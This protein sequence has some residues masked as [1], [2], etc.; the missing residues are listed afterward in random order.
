MSENNQP[1]IIKKYLM[2]KKVIPLLVI[3]SIFSLVTMVSATTPNPGHPWTEVGDGIW[4]ATGMTGFR[5]YTFPDATATVLT[6]NAL[7]TVAQ[8]GTG[9]NSTSSA[10]ASL[11]GM[12]TKG[13]MSIYSGTLPTRFPVGTDTFVLTADSAQPLGMKWAA[14]TSTPAGANTQIQFNDAGT[15]GATTSLTYD[16]STGNFGINGYLKL[17]ARTDP[18]APATNTD[19]VYAGT[20]SGK[21]M[22]KARGPLSN[23]SFPLQPSLFG[24]A[25]FSLMPGNG[26]TITSLGNT[27]TNSGTVTHVNSEVIGYAANFATA[28]AASS[29]TGT[30][31]ATTSYMLGTQV[32]SNG[33]F[34]NARLAFPDATTTGLLAFVGL[35]SATMAASVV[36][37]NP[38]AS[39]T[40]GFQYSTQRGDLGWKFV[41]NNGGT[42]TVSSVVLPFG[43]SKV[44][45]FY[46][47]SPPFPNNGVIY[48]RIDNITDGTTAEGQ[49]TLTLP[50][51][52]TLLR[53]GFQ[54]NNVTANVR[55]VRLGH[56]YVETDR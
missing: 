25:I 55:N 38:I 33:F 30:G 54:I 1:V 34:Y 43:V 56:L 44:M 21:T 41:T 45:D 12:T 13:D 6:T 15:M 2:P 20:V 19:M 32:G 17:N 9:Q 39:S 16:K 42:P 37:L 4:A 40:I 28:G 11:A 48:Y 36:A 46:I 23:S 51:G 24:P 8:G 18:A 35:T 47:Y 22:L 10:F 26:G 3:I 50:A 5:T 7:I 14:I 31:S 29:T 49:A 53:P 52:G 27:F